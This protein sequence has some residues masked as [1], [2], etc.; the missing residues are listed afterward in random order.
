[1]GEPGLPGARGLPGAS[2]PKV[3]L[4]LESEGADKEHSLS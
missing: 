4:D 2:G 3:T 1:M